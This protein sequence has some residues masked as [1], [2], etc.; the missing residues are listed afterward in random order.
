[1]Q[2]VEEFLKQG[3][4]IQTVET[5]KASYNAAKVPFPNQRQRTKKK[6]RGISIDIRK[7][8]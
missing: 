3:G 8:K 4:K 2:S 7:K 1:M 5:G 6:G